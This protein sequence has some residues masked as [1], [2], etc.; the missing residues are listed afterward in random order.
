V[1]ERLAR[2]GVLGRFAL[3]FVTVRGD[4]SPWRPYAIEI[5]LR[6]GGTTHTFMALQALTDGHYDA[7]RGDFTDSEGRP[8]YY[9]ATDHLE[10]PHYARLTPDD[11]FDIVAER[12]L[13][14]DEQT[15]S[16][17]AFHM[18]SAI[19]TAGR[20]GATAIASTRQGAD[21]LLEDARRVLDDESRRAGSAGV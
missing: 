8:L 9:T 17:V 4:A 5:N 16:G 19:A 10:S 15:M 12:G 11:L 6:C 20:V 14:W 1:G 13:G 21:D 18:V 2:E 3:D 7:K